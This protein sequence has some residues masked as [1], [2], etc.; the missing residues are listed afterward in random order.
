MTRGRL[1][2]ERLAG[3]LILIFLVAL[4]VFFAMRLLPGDPVDAILGNSGSATASQIQALRASYHLDRPVGEQL[5]LFIGGLVHGD[6]GE[7]IVYN[8]PVMSVILA[9]LPATGELALGA[10]L[11]AVLLALPIGVLS[12]TWRS[13]LLDRL[14]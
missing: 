11:M 14:S 2:A 3:T 10:V 1:L 12:A 9:R 6:L 7:S 5:L 8:Q 13:S 4:L